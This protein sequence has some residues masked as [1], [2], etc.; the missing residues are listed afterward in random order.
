[1]FKK[2]EKEGFYYGFPVALMTTQDPVTR[3]DNITPIS[4]TWT[5]SKSIV[6]GLGLHNKGYLNL[7]TGRHL[8][9]NI[10]D[11]TLWRNVESIAKTTGN[12]SIPRYKLDADYFFCEDKFKLGQFTKLRGET[13]VT[14]R[15]KECPIQIET[16][17]EN[18]MKRAD[19]AIIEC[20]IEGI[21]VQEYLLYDHSH[22]DVEKWQPLIYKFREYSTTEQSLGKNFRFQEYCK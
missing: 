4:S 20:K 2:I 14:A 12:E 9:L 15:I 11:K 21:F 17:V 13:V 3:A 6:I 7:E 5:L 1:M 10:P 8:T 16:T 18:I 19:F 22:I